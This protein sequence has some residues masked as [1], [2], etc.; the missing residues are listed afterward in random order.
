MYTYTNTLQ[1]TSVSTRNSKK[2]LQDVVCTLCIKK[3]YI[4][5]LKRSYKIMIK[6]NLKS[7]KEVLNTR[8]KLFY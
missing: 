6:F 2:Y 3:L 7:L 5:S 4:F 8:K 1:V